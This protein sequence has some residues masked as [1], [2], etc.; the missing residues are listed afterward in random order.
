MSQSALFCPTVR[1]YS[2]E[3]DGASIADSNAELDDIVEETEASSGDDIDRQKRRARQA[4]GKRGGVG[5]T[6]GDGDKITDVKKEKL[7][8]RSSSLGLWE[9]KLNKNN[10][11]NNNSSGTNSQNDH[12]SSTNFSKAAMRRS[13]SL[14][15]SSKD[16]GELSKRHHHASG[17]SSINNNNISNQH[18]SGGGHYGVHRRQYTQDSGI[19]AQSSEKVLRLSVTEGPRVENENGS[20]SGWESGRKTEERSCGSGVDGGKGEEQEE[21]GEEEDEKSAET[22]STKEGVKEVKEGSARSA[23]S[24]KESEGRTEESEMERKLAEWRRKRNASFKRRFT[25]GKRSTAE[26]VG[27]KEDEED[28]LDRDEVLEEVVNDKE[29]V[30]LEEQ[31]EEKEE[32]EERP[33][34]KMKEESPEETPEEEFEEE[35]KEVEGMEVESEEKTGD[36]EWVILSGNARRKSCPD[37][38]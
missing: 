22:G 35:V 25:I 32:E 21:E 20:G 14:R 3:E 10:N 18:G 23:K 8:R 28:R 15:T 16:S 11:G 19:S 17:G 31:E 36:E 2:A 4:D 30:E 1:R 33:W 12:P 5:D 38:R 34:K 27:Q 6:C 24:E 37:V 26:C 7:R 29:R 13:I 9:K